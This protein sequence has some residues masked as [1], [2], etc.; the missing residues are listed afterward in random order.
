MKIKMF[1]EPN[2][3]RIFSEHTEINLKN[4]SKNITLQTQLNLYSE[5]SP[6][7]MISTL[8]QLQIPHTFFIWIHEF[9][10][11]LE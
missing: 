5:S 3:I 8:G 11:F 1:H 7:H 4:S 10:Q 9:A 2:K 6:E